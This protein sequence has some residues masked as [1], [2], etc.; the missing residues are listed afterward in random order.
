MAVASAVLDKCLALD[1]PLSCILQTLCVGAV[2]RAN[3]YD[4]NAPRDRDVG[5]PITSRFETFCYHLPFRL[6]SLRWLPSSHVLENFQIHN[7]LSALL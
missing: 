5:S 4:S 2:C 3:T 6:S 7:L 1:P